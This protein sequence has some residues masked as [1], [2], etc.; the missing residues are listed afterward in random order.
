MLDLNQLRCF[1]TVAT[2]L[3]FSRAAVRLN[4]TQPPL[5]RQIKLLEHQLGVELFTRSTRSVALTA[6]GRAFFAE[7]QSLLERAQSAELSAKR[8][9]QGDIGTVKVSFVPIAVYEFLPKV[10]AELRVELPN[11]DI[12]LEEMNSFEQNEALRTRRIDLGIVRQVARWEGLSTERLLTEPFVLAI[13]AGHPLANAPRLTVRDMHRQ[14][15]LM[16]ANSAY[17]PFNEL[18]TGMFRREKVAPHYVQ[19]LGSTLT[20]LALVDAGVGLALIPRSA[21]RIRFENMTFREIE[22]GRGVESELHMIWHEDNDNPAFGH[23]LRAIQ[24]A[25]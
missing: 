13:P 11:I 20:I 16:Y 5:S 24:K 17:Q 23:L 3:S 7:A 22:L 14:P 25:V 6:A 2:E 9:A 18:L 19:W 12:S 8:F 21:Q 15:M 1:T 4:M 10:I